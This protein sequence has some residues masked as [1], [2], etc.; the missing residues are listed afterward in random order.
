MTLIEWTLGIGVVTLNL[1]SIR[2]HQIAIEL[3]YSNTLRGADK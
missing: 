3:K 2:L 1:I